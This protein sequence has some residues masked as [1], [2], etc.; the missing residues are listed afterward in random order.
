M[1]RTRWEDTLS[2]GPD[3]ADLIR[4]VKFNGPAS[5]CLSGCRSVCWKVFLLFR[6]SAPS[7]WSAILAEARSS[8]AAFRDQYLRY[9]KHPDQLSGLPLDPLADVPDSPWDAVRQDELIRAEILQDVQRLPDLPF[10]H[11]ESIQMM[12]LDIL[13]IYCKLDP[14]AGGYRQ[15]MHE[16]LAPL[17]FTVAQDAV[18][19]SSAL[20]A[21][22]S[23]TLDPTAL[24]GLDSDFI[25]HDSFALFFKIMDSAKTFYDLGHPS[26]APG[27]DQ[28]RIVTK[29][30]HIHEVLLMKVDP[31]LANHLRNIEVLPQIFLMW[32]GPA[33][34]MAFGPCRLD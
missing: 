11:Q 9:I 7:D 6:D 1:D 8:Y 5:P 13:F 10:Y 34:F 21:S 25:E 12:I 33:F 24:D 32:V 16:L 14:S 31:E 3:P 17:I 18:E 4:A 22:D 2:H 15:G 23:E 26:A 19:R 27:S 29:S 28:N 30:Q 20:S